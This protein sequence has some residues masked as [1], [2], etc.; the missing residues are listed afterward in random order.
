LGQKEIIGVLTVGLVHF[1]KK[2]I[3]AEIE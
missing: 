3:Q 2:H 1:L